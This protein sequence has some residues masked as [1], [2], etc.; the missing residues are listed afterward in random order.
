MNVALVI[1]AAAAIGGDVTTRR[2]AEV[3]L[4][5]SAAYVRVCQLGKQLATSASLS[6]ALRVY[7]SVLLNNQPTARNVWNALPVC[8]GLHTTCPLCAQ[9]CLSPIF[10]CCRSQGYRIATKHDLMSRA[11]LRASF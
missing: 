5:P 2:K 8:S 1:Q 10:S 4:L 3:V 6:Q 7:L 9:F 11:L